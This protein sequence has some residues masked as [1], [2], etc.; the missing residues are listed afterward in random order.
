MKAEKIKKDIEEFDH[1]VKEF[2]SNED[3]L[4]REEKQSRKIEFRRRASEINND[5]SKINEELDRLLLSTVTTQFSLNELFEN[6]KD[7]STF[8]ESNPRILF[9]QKRKENEWK[10]RIIT[11]AK[12]EAKRERER[13]ML[14]QLR[15]M[16]KNER[17]TIKSLYYN[18][19]EDREFIKEIIATGYDISESIFPIKRLV[20]RGRTLGFIQFLIENG[21]ELT[22]PDLLFL[23]NSGFLDCKEFF[24]AVVSS[25]K[26][27][28]KI[29]NEII[30]NN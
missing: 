29:L 18:G 24:E 11:E 10:N 22:R 16:G 13:S 27:D 26:V 9:E 6:L 8:S 15:N 14:V 25:E 4:S 3:F 30:E 23:K 2:T 20:E 21:L 28:E 1:S 7:K 17:E 5:L 19:P 12:L